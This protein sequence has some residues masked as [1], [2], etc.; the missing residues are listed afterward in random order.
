MLTEKDRHETFRLAWRHVYRGMGTIPWTKIFCVSV[1]FL[2][3]AWNGSRIFESWYRSLKVKDIHNDGSNKSNH[4]YHYDSLIF[5]KTKSNDKRILFQ[6]FG[7][8]HF[9][10]RKI[11]CDIPLLR[12]HHPGDVQRSLWKRLVGLVCTWQSYWWRKML[13]WVAS[14]SNHWLLM[15]GVLSESGRVLRLGIYRGHRALRCTCEEDEM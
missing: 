3:L 11:E 14:I 13:N 6:M 5:N 12:G 4:H 7:K 2:C 9:Q 15:P 8:I 10:K 1:S